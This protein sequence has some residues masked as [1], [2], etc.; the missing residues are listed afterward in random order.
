M[1]RVDPQGLP[2]DRVEYRDKVLYLNGEA[3]PQELVAQLP[4][5]LQSK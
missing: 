4:G 5:L 2:G 3:M 1:G